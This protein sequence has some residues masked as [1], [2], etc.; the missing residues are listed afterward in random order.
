MF[1]QGGVGGYSGASMIRK[2][3]SCRILV[4]ESVG[5]VFGTYC[6]V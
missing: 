5:G 6:S 3:S 1:R 2:I 4:L